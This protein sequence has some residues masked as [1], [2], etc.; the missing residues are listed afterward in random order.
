MQ[1]RVQER[2]KIFPPL[3]VFTKDRRPPAAEKLFRL[4]SFP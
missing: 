2:Q 4:F 1:V 3:P